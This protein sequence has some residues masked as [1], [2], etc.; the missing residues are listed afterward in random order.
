M[1]CW[2]S[3]MQDTVF[4]AKFPAQALEGDRIGQSLEMYKL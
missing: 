1:V 3:D 2:R 4:V